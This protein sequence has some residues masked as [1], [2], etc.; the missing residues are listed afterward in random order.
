MAFVLLTLNEFCTPEERATSSS[1]PH[2]FLLAKPQEDFS[3][4]GPDSALTVTSITSLISE[5][6]F[7]TCT[8]ERESLIHSSY[9][10]QSHS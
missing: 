5:E 1:N 10:R 6:I 3:N 8:T 2:L 7:L 4:K 9:G